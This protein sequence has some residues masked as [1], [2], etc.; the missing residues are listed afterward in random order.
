M[1][2]QS[3]ALINMALLS[4]G[5]KPRHHGGALIG[6]VLP[7]LPIFVFF[8]VEALILRHSQAEIWSERYFLPQWQ[9]FIDPF[10]SVPLILLGVGIGYLLRSD[11]VLAVCWSMLLHC[12]F[13][14]FL[15]REDAHRHFFPLWD[16]KFMSP[17]SYWEAD[18]HAGIVSAVEI[19]AMVGA[20]VY[21]FPR[22][23]SNFAK[24]AL[25]IVTTASALLYIAFILFFG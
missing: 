5:H 3:H 22:L 18:Y 8:G 23:Q 12:L 24:G 20:S 15:H 4:R 7:D 6:A 2:T 17:V 25:V 10:N 14:F 13:D 1:N 21:L 11:F 16:Y 19:A 9:N